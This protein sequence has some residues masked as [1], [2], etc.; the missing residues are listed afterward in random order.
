MMQHDTT[1]HDRHIIIH[2]NDMM[3]HGTTQH[4]RH[5]TSFLSPISVQSYPVACLSVDSLSD[6]QYNRDLPITTKV[7]LQTT[8][9]RRISGALQHL[10]TLQ[11]KNHEPLHPVHRIRAR[12]V[13]IYIYIYL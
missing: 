8:K 7:A 3:Q 4:D 2:E 5:F 1:Q 10:L 13:Y 9:K 12:V 6:T 11:A